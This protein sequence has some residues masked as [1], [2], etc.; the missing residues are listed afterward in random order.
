MEGCGS[1]LVSFG[2]AGKICSPPFRGRSVVISR[3][4]GAWYAVCW[5]LLRE[6]VERFE[7]GVV[8]DVCKVEVVRDGCDIGSFL[9]GIGGPWDFK[10]ATTG[11]PADVTEGRLVGMMLIEHRLVTEGILIENVMNELEG[12]R[13]SNVKK[14]AGFILGAGTG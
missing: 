14:A 7:V 3:H 8:G 9:D 2:K 4:R 1:V 5:K 13:N 11:A 12:C 6:K 10:D